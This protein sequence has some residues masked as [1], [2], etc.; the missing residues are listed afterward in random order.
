[1]IFLGLLLVLGLRT[2]QSSRYWFH[3][4]GAVAIQLTVAFVF[5]VPG[6]ETADDPRLSG[7]VGLVSLALGWGVPI[8]LTLRGYERKV[9]RVSVGEDESGVQ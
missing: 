8:G 4:V 5:E 6:Q 9:N 1:M 3:A 2:R 7:F